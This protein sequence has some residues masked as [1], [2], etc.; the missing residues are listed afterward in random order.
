M[1]E[2]RAGRF[3]LEPQKQDSALRNV[4]LCSMTCPNERATRHR[5]LRQTINFKVGQQCSTRKQC[6]FARIPQFGHCSTSTPP[7]HRACHPL[8]HP[9]AHPVAHPPARWPTLPA[10]IIVAPAA[11]AAIRAR[12]AWAARWFCWAG[13]APTLA[14][15]AAALAARAAARDATA[16]DAAAALPTAAAAGLARR[17][18]AA[19]RQGAWQGPR[20]RT[21]RVQL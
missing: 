16:A 14:A 20:L 6:V 1:S 3:H 2:V 7:P 9:L 4:L 8:A 19:W 15:A 10:D 18:A 21:L 11:A 5:Q 17:A 13:A 12:Q